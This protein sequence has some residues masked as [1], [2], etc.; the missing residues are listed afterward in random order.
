MHTLHARLLYFIPYLKK[1][2]HLFPFIFLNTSIGH[3]SSEVTII[4]DYTA[5]N[6]LTIY[7]ITQHNQKVSS[8]INLLDKD[9]PTTEGLYQYLASIQSFEDTSALIAVA[10]E[11]LTV[12]EASRRDHQKSIRFNHTY[13]EERAFH[14]LNFAYLMRHTHTHWLRY[15]Y[16]FSIIAFP[17][18]A[19]E[20]LEKIDPIHFAIKVYQHWSEERK[21]ELYAREI[22]FGGNGDIPLNRMDLKSLQAEYKKAQENFY[23][24][25]SSQTLKYSLKIESMT[26]VT[27]EDKKNLIGLKSIRDTLVM[28]MHESNM[29]SSQQNPTTD[30]ETREWIDAPYAFALG[31][32]AATALSLAS[33]GMGQSLN[34]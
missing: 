33:K 30:P 9:F 14:I 32:A 12:P 10:K 16:A 24:L 13:I 3:G 20:K 2:I 22:H 15:Y 31:A 29:E 17:E 11:L 21:S 34:H 6:R 25:M 7:P 28:K 27:D 1:T 8:L 5:L 26:C 19:K 18:S 23:S 4:P